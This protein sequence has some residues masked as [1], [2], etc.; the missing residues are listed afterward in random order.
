MPRAPR[1]RAASATAQRRRRW[2]RCV[3]TH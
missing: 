1:A 3:A 2:A